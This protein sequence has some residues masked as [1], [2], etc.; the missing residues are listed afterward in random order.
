[1]RRRKNSARIVQR[2]IDRTPAWLFLTVAALVMVFFTL[3]TMSEMGWLPFEM[4]GWSDLLGMSEPYE[5]GAQL[6]GEQAAAVHMIDVGQGDS[7]LIQTR[8]KTVLIDAGE[9]DQGQTVCDYLKSA[10]VEKLDLVIATHPHSDHIGGMADVLFQFA[11]DEILMPQMTEDMVP[12]TSVFNRLLDEVEKQNVP[13]TAAQPGLVYDLG[14]GVELTVLAPLQVYDSLNVRA[15]YH[16]LPHGFA[17]QRCLCNRWNRDCGA[18]RKGSGRMSSWSIDRIE[19]G[20]AVCEGPDD[21]VIRLEVS[22]LPAGAREGDCL[23][24]DGD[25]RWQVD[26]QLTRQRREE[27]AKRLRALFGKSGPA[28]EPDR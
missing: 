15:R 12:T 27:T 9:R 5:P 26:E 8:E 23:F 28:K 18:H 3:M 17:G 21:A 4:P 19:E 14:S 11:A 20:W 6:E 22:R 2:L 13:V 7:I 24:L 25:G 10:G 1:M 16:R